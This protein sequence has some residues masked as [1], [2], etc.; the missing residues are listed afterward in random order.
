MAAANGA[1]RPSRAPRYRRARPAATAVR[2]GVRA[3]AGRRVGP[4]GAAGLGVLSSVSADVLA[5]LLDSA[6]ERAWSTP[7]LGDQAAKS[8]QPDLNPVPP[9]NRSLERE[10]RRSVGEVLGAGNKHADDLRSD[11]AMVMREIDAGGTLF[12]AAIDAGD[13]EFEREVLVAVETLSAEFG[14]MAFMLAD[15]ARAAGEIQDSLAGQDAE[16][17]AASEQVERQSADVRMI[18]EELAVIDKHTR[19]WLPEPESDA[20]GRRWTG[21]SPYRG[22]LPYGRDHEAVFYGRER[23]TAELAG[24][25]AGTPIVMLTG[26][27]GTGKTSLLQAGLVPTLARGVQVPGSSSW[28]VV[29]LS[30]TARPLAD[31]AA[32][33]AALGGGDPAAIRQMLA[34]AP[35]EAHLLV[36]EILLAA[37]DPARL[38]L[39]IDQFEQVF[40]ADGQD[41]RLERTAF[42]DVV[43]AAATQ[44]A[45]LAGEPPARVVIAVRGDHWDRCAAYPQLVRSMKDGQIVVGP[46]P[47]AGLRRVIT[48]QAEASGLRVES[49]LIDAIVADVDA[50]E[51]GPGGAALPLLSQALTLTCENRD[52]DWL[53]REGYERAGRVARSVEVSAEDV[54]AGLSHDQQ[55]VARDMFRRMTSVGPDRRP[56]RR[57]VS[58]ADLYAGCPKNQRATVGM[59]LDAFAGK[60][61]LVLGAD[62]AEIAHDVVLQAWPRL[63]DWLEED[64][65]SLILYGQLAEDTTR[66]RQNGK[67]SSLLYRGVQLAAAK[68]ATRV[69]AADPGRYPALTTG[70]TDFL[71]AGSGAATRSRWGRRTLATAVIL[72]L[73]AALAGAGQQI[74]VER[75]SAGHQRSAEVSEHLAA[76]STALEATDP[77]TAAL[78]AGAAW[79]I[80]PTAQAHW[81]PAGVARPAD[82]R[83]PRR[84]VGRGDCR[85]LESGRQD[86]GWQATP[87]A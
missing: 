27:S 75:S 14:D 53:G 55:A 20:P 84:P 65:S 15:L 66:W 13:E 29:S 70:E 35:G 18:R 16:L 9:I 56:V 43:C 48:G 31:L 23:L 51:G 60:H 34:E 77:V 36:R 30:A 1:K 69:W 21:G 2:G 59:V 26:G 73:L 22:L 10:I 76:Q 46:M 17:R 87:A 63:R 45:G 7:G 61:L 57:L 42:I 74:R 67:D 25:L 33:L 8:P 40:A 38:V 6:A 71:R 11:V 58:R 80:S 81:Q 83:D 3:S 82:A 41:A 47:E 52:G 12:R 5:G 32:G 54:Y 49:A 85:G 50:A 72:V 86:R 19:Q 37:G 4:G 64:Q 79:R 24:K 68:E 39:I 28:P 78:L 62:S 44:P